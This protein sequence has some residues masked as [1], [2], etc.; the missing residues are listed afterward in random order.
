VIRK[1]SVAF[2][3]IFLTLAPPAPGRAAGNF[4]LHSGV[5]LGA[6][7]IRVADLELADPVLEDVQAHETLSTN[8]SY[9]NAYLHVGVNYRVSAVELRHNPE[10]NYIEQAV[11]INLDADRWLR[12]FTGT[13]SLTIT[14]QMAINPSLP[15]IDPRVTD[16][17]NAPTTTPPGGT[18][19]QGTTSGDLL[20]AGNLVNIR[21]DRSG[22]A[23]IYGLSYEDDLGPFS[24]YT[25]GWL[26]RDNRYNS[27]VIGDSAT[28]GVNGDY[29]TR[30]RIGDA[31]VGVSHGR[32]VRGGGQDRQTYDVHASLARG[33]FRGG[34]RVAPGVAYRTDTH[35]YGAALD[36]SGFRRRRVL[37]Y[38]GYYRTNYQ[39]LDIGG[40]TLTRTQHVGVTVR[41]TRPTQYPRSVGA[42]SV[43]S[44]VSRQYI[45]SA[46]QSVLISPSLRASIGYERGLLRWMDTST[47]QWR[48]RH[49]DTV[50]VALNWQFL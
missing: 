1:W 15:P 22:Y 11:A 35:A 31:G 45:L 7:Y 2:A 10:L 26:V 48:H 38:Q 13:G 3:F 40:V 17:P 6:S 23:F 12:R 28:L 47:D 32:F 33:T 36:L 21:E 25:V 20:T 16:A 37:S 19:D 4:S 29:V 43:F 39:L 14:G 30:L 44:S 50:L 42:E 24:S 18:P 27:D 49:S 46:D 34:W 5:G 41:P 8:V 9:D